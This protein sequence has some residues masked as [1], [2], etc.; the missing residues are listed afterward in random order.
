MGITEGWNVGIA[1]SI[2]HAVCLTIVVQVAG[3]GKEVSTP[4][5][6]A[7]VDGRMQGRYGDNRLVIGID[8]E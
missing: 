7:A 2:T 5:E 1:F 3:P 4:E 6:I 8:T